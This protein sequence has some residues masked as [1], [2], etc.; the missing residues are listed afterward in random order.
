[1]S[2]GQHRGRPVAIKHLRVGAKDEF[3]KI[4]KVSNRDR[5]G[6]SQSLSFNSAALSGSHHL[7]TPISSERL[8]TVGGFRIQESAIF[9]HSLRVDAQRKRD[10]IHKVQSRGQPLAFGK[11]H[12]LLVRFHTN[13]P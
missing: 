10:G 9:S 2:K 5:P 4:F 13:T 3:D 12:T 1:V 8:A 7:E 6:T 11:S